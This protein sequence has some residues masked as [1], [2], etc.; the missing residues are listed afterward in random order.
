MKHYYIVVY[1]SKI[2]GRIFRRIT[3]VSRRTL[4]RSF[5]TQTF[6][7]LSFIKISKRE[8]THLGYK[9]D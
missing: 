8:A 5:D 2:S 7:L 6:I 4:I 3:Y 1:Q 9:F